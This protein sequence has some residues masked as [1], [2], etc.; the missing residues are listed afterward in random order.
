LASSLRRSG[1]DP[2]AIGS[3]YGQ[4]QRLSGEH[5]GHWR[6]AWP[7]ILHIT[8]AAGNARWVEFLKPEPYMD[9]VFETLLQLDAEGFLVIPGWAWLGSK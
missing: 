4:Q 7:P 9:D 6:W 8:A 2:N 3:A 1:T 5:P